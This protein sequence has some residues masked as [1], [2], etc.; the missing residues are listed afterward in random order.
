MMHPSFAFAESHWLICW[1]LF[2]IFLCMVHCVMNCT[3]EIIFWF[4]IRIYFDDLNFHLRIMDLN[5]RRRI[6]MKKM[7]ES[8]TVANLTKLD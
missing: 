3:G 8:F 2:Y 7:G 4:F 1:L 6:W 5:H